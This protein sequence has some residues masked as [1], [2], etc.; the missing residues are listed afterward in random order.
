MAVA[1]YLYNTR[2]GLLSRDVGRI[3]QACAR[4]GGAMLRLD[5]TFVHHAKRGITTLRRFSDFANQSWRIE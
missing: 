4:R 2:E 5:V 3:A 1:R